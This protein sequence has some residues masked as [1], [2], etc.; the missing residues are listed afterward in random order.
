MHRLT[1]LLLSLLAHYTHAQWD[2]AELTAQPS[3]APSFIDPDAAADSAPSN[4]YTLPTA[5]S[6]ENLVPT[7][8][9]RDPCG[10]VVQPIPNPAGNTCNASLLISPNAPHPYGVR[11]ISDP[12]AADDKIDFG[13][14]VAQTIPAICDQLTD[15]AVQK[16]KW[17]WASATP[18]SVCWMGFW[19][20]DDGNAAK[21]ITDVDQCKN[22]IF[23]P[24]VGFCNPSGNTGEYNLGSVNIVRVP[25]VLQTGRQVDSGYPSYVLATRKLTVGGAG[26]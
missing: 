9:P 26:G 1:I 20:P 8:P 14:C 6:I 4:I 10:P 12:W 21:P 15:P 16:G 24:M 23:M 2:A 7:Q 3:A 13:A 18:P 19:L 25:D 17:I 22:V 11:C 5:S